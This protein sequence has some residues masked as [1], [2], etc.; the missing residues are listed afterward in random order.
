MEHTGRL[1]MT[2]NMM[3]PMT[4]AMPQTQYAMP[5]GQ[6]MMPQQAQGPAVT[7][8]TMGGQPVYINSLA[9]LPPGAIPLSQGMMAQALGQGQAVQPQPPSTL[10]I[11]LGSALKFG[12][13]GGAA[14]A[15][16]GVIPFLPL[17]LFSGGLV[18][19]L[20]GAALGVVMGLRKAKTQKA[21]FVAL[22]QASQAQTNAQAGAVAGAI[23]TTEPAGAPAPAKVLPKQAAAAKAPKHPNAK[24]WTDGDG[25]LRQVGTGKVLKRAS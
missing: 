12:A 19:A 25:N 3:Q 9:Q 10:K 14:G 24:T 6:Y 18:G 20:G 17:G 4:T 16:I 2:V 15:A 22:Q 21:E 5:Q 1:P 11:V 23:G 13:I 8:P 7:A